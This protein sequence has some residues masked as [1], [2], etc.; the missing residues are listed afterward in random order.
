MALVR[1][2]SKCGKPGVIDTHCSDHLMICFECFD[3][4]NDLHHKPDC[5]IAITR[6]IK[7][8]RKIAVLHDLIAKQK[9][10]IAEAYNNE[11]ALECTL[12][13]IDPC[14]QCQAQLKKMACR[15]CGGTGYNS[16]PIEEEL[17]EQMTR[18]I[19]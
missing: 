12:R 1:E 13:E 9:N 8:I 7:K 15:T 2:C 4:C 11:E 3:N 19:H 18:L 14:L 16:K 5:Q 6:R 17:S 10:I